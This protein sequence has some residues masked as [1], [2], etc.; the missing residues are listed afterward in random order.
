MVPRLIAVF[1]LI[2]SSPAPAIAQPSFAVAKQ[3]HA[4]AQARETTCADAACIAA[5]Y[6]PA[7]RAYDEYIAH[8]GSD[9]TEARYFRA[10]ILHF[11]LQ[12]EEEAGDLYLLVGKVPGKLQR[13][14]LVN[15]VEAFAATQRRDKLYAA[16]DLYASQLSGPE[17]VKVL[18]TLAQFELDHGNDDVA[19]ARFLLIV[20]KYPAARE[21]GPAGDRMLQIL[22]KQR[23]Y[24][25]LAELAK[26]LATHLAFRSKDRQ[27]ALARV[28]V[29]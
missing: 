19:A 12:R 20:T 10:D 8:G 16:A 11:K 26:T 17:I 29:E 13:D 1:A 4:D 5:L 2:A 14:A 18:F 23:K 15:A 9:V 27:V 6:E 21:A 7:A 28:R 25:A 24:A 3:L 22:A